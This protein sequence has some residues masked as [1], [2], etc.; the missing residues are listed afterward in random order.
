[1]VLTKSHKHENLW[2][3]VSSDK[4]L[5]QILISIREKRL[6]L[7]LFIIQNGRQESFIS[8]QRLPSQEN[9]SN[10]NESVHSMSIERELELT[11]LPGRRV[12]ITK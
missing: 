7:H 10:E 2:S 4:T 5:F 1:M 11:K 6:R 3:I 9:E 8:E 12:A